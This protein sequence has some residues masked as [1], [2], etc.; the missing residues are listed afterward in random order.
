MTC[1]KSVCSTHFDT[2]YFLKQRN[3][4]KA[5]S[6]GP[7]SHICLTRVCLPMPGDADP[8]AT[9]CFGLTGGPEDRRTC[10]VHVIS[11]WALGLWLL[12][13]IGKFVKSRGLQRLLIRDLP[14]QCRFLRCTRSGGL[15]SH[16]VALSGFHRRY[17]D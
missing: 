16:R 12:D 8:R 15:Q 10:S 2:R 5:W 1:Q 3:Y 6:H 14:G 4:Y 7:M 11:P 13:A 17:S 9:A